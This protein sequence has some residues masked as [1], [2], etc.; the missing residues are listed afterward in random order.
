MQS[1]M[2]KSR[3]LVSR[4][5]AAAVLVVAVFTTHSF[6][7]E[8]VLD[9]SLEV[10]GLFLLSIATLGRLWALMYIS[11]NKTRELITEGPYSMVRHPLYFFSLVMIW[12][13]PDLSLDRL[14]FNVLWT[15]WTA[16]ATALEERDLVTYLGDAY[17]E[18]QRKVPML[19]PW[20]S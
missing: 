6:G 1:V 7:Q 19:I 14:L 16:F 18:Y 17:E 8:G 3:V 2:V 11:G 4:V 5:F 13:C 10:S 15:G 9:I 20:R 12:S